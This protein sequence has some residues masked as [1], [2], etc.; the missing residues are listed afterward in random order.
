MSGATTLIHDRLDS[1]FL[2]LNADRLGRRD[3][4]FNTADRVR[5]TA[6]ELCSFLSHKWEHSAEKLICCCSLER[7]LCDAVFVE[8]L[9]GQVQNILC[10]AEIN[11]ELL[12]LFP[13]PKLVARI[14]LS[15][16]TGTRNIYSH[17]GT[18]EN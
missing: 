10:R 6:D 7:Q 2:G 14:K 12:C 16:T 18:K 11:K 4:Q 17:Y 5:V 3:S 8:R 13:S 15:G 9:F 1:V